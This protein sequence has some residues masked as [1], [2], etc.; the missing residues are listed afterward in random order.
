MTWFESWF[1]GAWQETLEFIDPHEKMN[2]AQ[3]LSAR[4]LLAHGMALALM[5][6]DDPFG[7]E[8][9]NYARGL[10]ERVKAIPE[11]HGQAS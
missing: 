8:A 6:T 4:F 7:P 3:V 11:A 2:E 10:M 1:E 9:I 5:H